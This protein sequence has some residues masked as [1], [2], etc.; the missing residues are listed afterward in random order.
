MR[1]RSGFSLIEILIVIALLAILIALLL[2]AIQKVREAVARMS[3]V[4]NLKQISLATHNY[5]NANNGELPSLDG[6]PRPAYLP[7]FGMWARPVEPIVFTG[8]LP[9]LEVFTFDPKKPYPFVPVYLSPSD[10]TREYVDGNSKPS[11][12]PANAWAFVGHASLDRTF[13]DGLTN[14]II[15]AEHY[16]Q[17]GGHL[18]FVYDRQGRP[19]PDVRGRWADPQRA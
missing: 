3:S 12:Y 8:I 13:T 9:Y 11:S 2:P 19:S 6:R 14:T 5:A 15:F 10:P 7:F 17:C 18:R 4:N 16:Y 1:S